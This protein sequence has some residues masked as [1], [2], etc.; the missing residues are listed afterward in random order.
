MCTFA[1]FRDGLGGSFVRNLLGLDISRLQTWACFQTAALDHRKTFGGPLDGAER[2]VGHIQK[3]F[4]VCSTGERTVILGI[5]FAMNY[6]ELADE[7]A[8]EVGRS[9]LDFAESTSGEHLDAA[10]ACI[11]RRD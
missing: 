7:L 6:R 5:L 10:I 11:R 8:H 3:K 4:G 1:E 9:F 2:F